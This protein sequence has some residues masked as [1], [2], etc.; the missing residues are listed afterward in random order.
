MYGERE[1]SGPLHLAAVYGL[2]TIC[3]KIVGERMD[4]NSFE[5]AKS[6]LWNAKK[7]F[8]T[9]PDSEDVGGA[10]ALHLAAYHGRV[11]VVKVLVN[12]KA[13][14]NRPDAR[15]ITP[16]GYAIL[17]GCLEIVEIL[18]AADADTE[19]GRQSAL[20]I[21][22]NNNN[23]QAVQLLFEKADPDGEKRRK[24]L[25]NAA[26]TDHLEVVKQFIWEDRV[27][28]RSDQFGRTLL[29]IA[30]SH[31]ARKIVQ[32][33]LEQN[34]SCAELDMDGSMPL[35]LAAS[36]GHTFIVSML[37][38]RTPD[39]SLANARG[40]IAL[41]RA[42]EGTHGD[43]IQL[44]LDSGC[45]PETKDEGGCTPLLRAVMSLGTRKIPWQNLDAVRILV[46]NGADLAAADLQG[47]T[48]LHHAALLGQYETVKHLIDCGADADLLDI[49]GRNPLYIAAMRNDYRT[50]ELLM[51]HTGPE[52][53]FDEDNIELDILRM[54]VVNNFWAVVQLLLIKY[55]DTVTRQN[56]DGFTELH[57]AA[58]RGL[59][60][61]ARVLMRHGADIEARTSD[62]LTPLHLAAM[63]GH[64][65]ILTILGESSRKV[66]VHATAAEETGQ[67]ALHMAAARGK[68]DV[69]KW[70]IMAGA[71]L[72]MSD[73]L[74][75]TA[76]DLAVENGFD[77]VVEVMIN[78]MENPAEELDVA[79][80]PEPLPPI[81]VIRVVAVNNDDVEGRS[82][83]AGDTQ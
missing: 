70:L 58:M 13:E 83:T 71:D 1:N 82:G 16:L 63:N 57:V 53:I 8:E 7:G 14:I 31:S 56:G 36:E 28:E 3:Q 77:D 37:L 38:S 50:V 66:N 65:D 42:A 61:V 49:Y 4:D 60:E 72:E 51:N 34:A 78:S 55:P 43:V 75:R 12:A 22:V 21:A 46:A 25:F 10:S 44:L 39:I 32:W 20:E 9:H 33:L 29:H 52:F 5:L 54:A 30:S 76:L 64:V 6:R 40:Q 68:S 59:S 35:T 67:T 79:T 81:S 23:W 48:A 62:G 80:L 73:G 11:E 17:C 19:A 24:V 69:V 41:H 45:S 18:V 2:A 47:C 26:A 15:G 74:G 27:L